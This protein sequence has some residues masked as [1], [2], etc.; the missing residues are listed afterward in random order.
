MVT[1]I[2]YNIHTTE[3]ILL[4]IIDTTKGVLQR[5]TTIYNMTSTTILYIIERALQEDTTGEY[6]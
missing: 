5:D 2:I 1:R 3:R 6:Y 4:Y